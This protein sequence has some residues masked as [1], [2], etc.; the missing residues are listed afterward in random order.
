MLDQLR[1][2]PE[3]VTPLNWHDVLNAPVH[4]QGEFASKRVYGDTRKAN[5][6]L[7]VVYAMLGEVKQ[8]MAMS[9]ISY[10]HRQVFLPDGTR[11][12]VIRNGDQN[13][14]EIDVPTFTT[15]KKV[16]GESEG[17]LVFY[18][19][20]G[21]RILYSG[22]KPNA[23]MF[24]TCDE[25][26]AEAQITV[27][28]PLKLWYGNQFTFFEQSVYSWDHTPF[29]DLRSSVQ[30]GKIVYKDGAIWKQFPEHII[31]FWAGLVEIEKD[32]ETFSVF[33][34]LATTVAIDT[35]LRCYELDGEDLVEMGEGIHLFPDPSLPYARQEWPCRFRDDG[36]E[37]S[38]LYR[39]GETV[40]VP[41][42]DY[43]GD[44]QWLNKW[45]VRY[46]SLSATIV[47]TPDGIVVTTSHEDRGFSQDWTTHHITN[48][49]TRTATPFNPNWR[50][51]NPE[52]HNSSCTASASRSTTYGGTAGTAL[53]TVVDH[54]SFIFPLALNYTP[55]GQLRIAYQEERTTGGG[56]QTTSSSGTATLGH[57]YQEGYVGPYCM[58]IVYW[59]TTEASS[60]SESASYSDQGYS[61]TITVDGATLVAGG[62]NISSD[63][64]YSSAGTTSI[65]TKPSRFSDRT[66]T[67]S[68][69]TGQASQV[70]NQRYGSYAAVLNYINLRDMTYVFSEAVGAT[71][72]TTLGASEATEDSTDGRQAVRTNVSTSSRTTTG[73]VSYRVAW[74]IHG[75]PMPDIIRS[76]TQPETVENNVGF[77]GAVGASGMPIAYRNYSST[78]TAHLVR[79]TNIPAT[80]TEELFHYVWDERLQCPLPVW[81]YTIKVQGALGQPAVIQSACTF[82]PLQNYLPELDSSGKPTGALLTDPRLTVN[83]IGLF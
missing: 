25:E 11:V 62:N 79:S 34:Y 6:Y 66:G 9:D 50:Q 47:H 8:Q 44:I 12:R 45:V 72:I 21:Q 29:G 38:M 30:G 71:Q 37:A 83:P 70:I 39:Y 36:L 18:P 56:S 35:K 77:P 24:V 22:D 63:S 28:A 52:P 20:V 49:E 54:A 42:I 78:R 74:A 19:K 69:S 32:G 51:P 40:Q 14:V 27:T 31:G 81:A 26:S 7:P 16:Y 46:R 2:Q 33:R 68:H 67:F 80:A 13:I 5:A 60:S 10:G 43:G 76:Q 48:S 75:T 41:S 4:Q 53:A 15:E 17:G 55:E 82:G 3:R 64:S 1:V 65:K 59:E 73:H 58:P 23:A 61:T 57:E